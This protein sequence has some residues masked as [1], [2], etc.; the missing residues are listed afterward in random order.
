MRIAEL[1]A[2]FAAQSPAV[3]GGDLPSAVASLKQGS[4]EAAQAINSL[5]QSVGAMLDGLSKTN[6]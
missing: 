5:A 3:E 1:A 4:D 2:Q 6:Q